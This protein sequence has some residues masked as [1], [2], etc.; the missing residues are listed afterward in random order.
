M[1]A[2]STRAPPPTPFSLA[3]LPPSP[4]SPSHDHAPA[5]P[6]AS[7][8]ERYWPFIAVTICS[9]YLITLLPFIAPGM[10]LLQYSLLRYIRHQ[11]EKHTPR[12][13]SSPS[14]PRKESKLRPRRPS[15]KAPVMEVIVEEEAEA[16]TEADEEGK[17]KA[18]VGV[19]SSKP[20]RAV[21]PLHSHRPPPLV[22]P[23]FSGGVIT[24][25][26]PVPFVSPTAFSSSLASQPVL[27][28]P[29]AFFPPAT[30]SRSWPIESLD[31][32]E[33]LQSL[34]HSSMLTLERS[35]SL[36]QQNLLAATAALFA[37]S[38]F[39]SLATPP[40]KGPSQ[41]SSP[42]LPSP[43]SPRC[44][45]IGGRG[46]AGRKSP[47]TFSREM[48]LSPTPPLPAVAMEDVSSV[49]GVEVWKAYAGEGVVCAV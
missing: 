29:P 37:P 17:T 10:L 26:L 6:P 25:P 14:F 40:L 22:I 8:L 7:S 32:N 43:C 34:L 12:I 30:P 16:E 48:P 36:G 4:P 2:S 39:Q 9:I 28:S 20:T 35:S 49:E 47:F 18:A 3:D 24:H 45:P 27:S 38:M 1:P 15:L 13:S 31:L 44:P 11:K 41:P 23:P 21:S 19:G 42:S 5:L 46:S 33:S